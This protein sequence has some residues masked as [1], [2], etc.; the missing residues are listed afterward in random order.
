MSKELIIPIFIPHLGCEHMCVFCNQ[1]KISGQAK[2]PTLE[3]IKEKVREYRQ[4]CSNLAHREVQ[5]AFYGGSFTGIDLNLQKQ[6]L[7]LA[8]DLKQQGLIAKIRLSTRADYISDEV[9]ERLKFYQVDIVELGVQSM[10]EEVLKLSKRGHTAE[11]VVKA[12]NLIKQAGMSLGLQMMIALPGD[13]PEKSLSTAQKIIDLKPD[14]VR[15]YPTA[16]IK[17]TELAELWQKGAYKPWDWDILLDT[18]AKIAM[19]F[20]KNNI[21]IIRIG[22]QAADNLNLGQDLLGGAYH[23]ALGELVKGR[24]RRMC[25]E[26]KLKTMPENC[27]YIISCAPKML[28]QF[29]GQKNC[30]VLY[31]AQKYHQRLYIE[32]DEQ[33]NTDEPE[34]KPMN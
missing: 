25:L 12:A 19:L 13:T 21:L 22:L 1:R 7:S 8:H 6:F 27:A 29:K 31:F 28:S 5:L 30:N 32:A 34:I 9:L 20:Q 17:D 33:I 10:D 14:F 11:D 15:I 3:E 16:I 23:P 26:E 2:I 18:T 4:S 24:I